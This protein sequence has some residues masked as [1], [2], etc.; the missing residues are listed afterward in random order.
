VGITPCRGGRRGLLPNLE[1][2]S[3]SCQRADR[4]LSHHLAA[5]VGSLRHGH[6]GGATGDE[7]PAERG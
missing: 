5:R 4:L 2:R 1:P 3:F 6:L 7:L